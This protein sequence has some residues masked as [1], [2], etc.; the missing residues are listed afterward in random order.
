MQF[1]VTLHNNV[2]GP[3][4]TVK[5]DVGLDE[6]CFDA[7]KYKRIQEVALKSHKEPPWRPSHLSSREREFVKPTK[8]S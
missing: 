7:C 4:K 6:C 1:Q 8:I 2:T 3:Q 5:R